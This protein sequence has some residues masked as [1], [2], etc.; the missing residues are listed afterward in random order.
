MD[1]LQI[2]LPEDR[3]QEGT[4]TLTVNGENITFDGGNQVLGRSVTNNDPNVTNGN[5]PTG[6]ATVTSSEVVDRDPQGKFVNEDG[7]PVSVA[8]SEPSERVQAQGRYYIYLIPESGDLL[9]SNRYGIGLHGGGTSLGS[10]DAL[11][12]QQTLVPTNGCPRGTNQTVAQIV[13]RVINASTNGR[14]FRVII[15]EQ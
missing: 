8:T 9:T 15:T 1:T 2:N 5:T 3:N 10:K 14:V 12:A 4:M 7:T 11:Q 13:R 6:I